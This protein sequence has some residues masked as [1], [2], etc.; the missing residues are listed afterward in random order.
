MST[1]QLNAAS[2]SLNITEAM[3]LQL[4]KAMDRLTPAAFSKANVD[5]V[6]NRPGVYRLFIGNDPVYV[7]KA[8]KSLRQRLTKHLEKTLGRI[9]EDGTPL[10]EHMEFYCLYI[11]ED[12]HALA[13]EKML[14]REFRP[15]MEAEWNFNG[16]GNNDPGRRRDTS[17]VRKNHF[18]RAYPIDLDFQV[19]LDD[20]ATVD[21]LRSLLE[22]LKRSAPFLIRFPKNGHD[23]TLDTIRVELSAGV[24]RPASVREWL[25]KIAVALPP[26]WLITTLPGYVIIYPESNPDHYPSRSGSWTTGPTARFVPH[27]ATF[28]EG[29]EIL[30]GMTG[31]DLTDSEVYSSSDDVY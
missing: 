1:H 9:V 19:Q 10:A 4:V 5:A 22:A 14:I 23:R 24:T 21:S 7:G 12:L 8:D 11:D 30:E 18:D 31:G 27:A 16:F 13:P 17:V 15:I 3:R 20:L 2:F 29:G 25:Q 26:D 6:D 28:G